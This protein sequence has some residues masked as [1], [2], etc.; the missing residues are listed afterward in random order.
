M[1]SIVATFTDKEKAIAY[2]AINNR[3]M[4]AAA[5]M[6][7][8]I[9]DDFYCI[10]EYETRDE[11]LHINPDAEFGYFFESHKVRACIGRDWYPTGVLCT[12]PD[13]DQ[14]NGNIFV[15]ELDYDRAAKK[16]KKIMTDIIAMEKGEELL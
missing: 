4:V 3:D 14:L 6:D 16:A 11:F 5:I 8:P 1:A 2:C 7:K 10:E 15:K 12:K 13:I 9:Y